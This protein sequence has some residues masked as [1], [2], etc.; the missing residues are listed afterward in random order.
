MFTKQNVRNALNIY[1][2][3]ADYHFWKDTDH[4]F[5]MIN[6]KMAKDFGHKSAYVS[7]DG[8]TDYQHKCKAVEMA[9]EF[10]KNDNF[11]ISQKKSLTMI[12]MFFNNKSELN[13]FYVKKS[14][15]FD[16]KNNVIGVYG[17]AIDSTHCPIIRSA[18][19]MLT[20]DQLLSLH[21]LSKN[22]QISYQIKTSYDN[23]DLTFRES[24]VLFNVVRCKPDKWIANQLGISVKTV[25]N[26]TDSLRR[27][28][29]CQNRSQLRDKAVLSGAAT[30]LLTTIFSEHERIK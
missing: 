29:N 15:L 14:P 7:F 13:L 5:R 4:V 8:I 11:V 24:Q 28:F 1:N 30:N 18:L 17:T 26:Y 25:N 10:I 21:E 20:D 27:K 19:L 12:E 2:S 22:T 6:E 23:L 16:T 9:D 3:S